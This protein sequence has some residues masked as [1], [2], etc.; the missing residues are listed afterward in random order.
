MR[1][2]LWIIPLLF[3]GCESHQQGNQKTG[4]PTQEIAPKVAKEKAESMALNWEKKIPAAINRGKR[5][6]KPVMILVTSDGCKWCD[7]LRETTLSDSQVIAKLNKDFI[8][9]QGY[10]NRGEVPRELY[11]SGT[12]GTWFLKNGEPM[13]QPLMGALPKDQYIEALDIVLKEFQ[14]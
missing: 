13:F 11:T 1:P 14:K 3:L 2:L 4:K 9:A 6:H 7:I 12:P 10:T 8:I 5:E